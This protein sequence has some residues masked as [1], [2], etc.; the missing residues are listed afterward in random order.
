MTVLNRDGDRMDKLRWREEAGA[1]LK[2]SK[3][4]DGE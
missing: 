4:R 3:Q 2:K 1:R